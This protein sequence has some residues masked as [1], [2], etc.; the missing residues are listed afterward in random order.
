MIVHDIVTYIIVLF[1]IAYWIMQ[2]YLEDSS[3]EVVVD[4]LTCVQWKLSVAVECPL[5]TVWRH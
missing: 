3:V 4:R 2:E 1:Q 5:Q